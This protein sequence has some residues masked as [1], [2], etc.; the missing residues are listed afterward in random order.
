MKVR[1]WETTVLTGLNFF[2]NGR[3]IDVEAEY[4]DYAAYYENL[5]HDFVY[6]P[7]CTRCI[8]CYSKL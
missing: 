3:Q 8:F 4:I 1:F 6:I 7:Y 5:D 2:K